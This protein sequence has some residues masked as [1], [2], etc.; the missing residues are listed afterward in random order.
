MRGGPQVGFKHKKKP[1]LNPTRVRNL[2]P[3]KRKRLK[4]RIPKRHKEQR[5]Q[6]P[7]NIGVVHKQQRAKRQIKMLKP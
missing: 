5:R 3:K 1:V 2:N 4:I 6:K 7:W